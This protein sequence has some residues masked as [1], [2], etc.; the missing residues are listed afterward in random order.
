MIRSILLL[1]ILI[2]F[3]LATNAAEST[4][5]QKPSIKTKPLITEDPKIL[6]A[7]NDFF[8]RIADEGKVVLKDISFESIQNNSIKMSIK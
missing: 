1:S 3:S 7:A 2:N 6:K 4:I 5:E 8:E